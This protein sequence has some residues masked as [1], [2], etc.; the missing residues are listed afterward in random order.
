MQEKSEFP[1]GQGLSILTA[2]N[3]DLCGKH[4]LC[5][6]VK[7]DISGLIVLKMGFYLWGVDNSVAAPE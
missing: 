1:K 4:P 7:T 5:K 6:L 2:T 3:H